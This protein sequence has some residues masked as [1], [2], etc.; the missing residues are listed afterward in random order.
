[1]RAATTKNSAV[2]SAIAAMTGGRVM[3]RT[4]HSSRMKPSVTRPM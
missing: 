1:L 4:F 2:R 3:K